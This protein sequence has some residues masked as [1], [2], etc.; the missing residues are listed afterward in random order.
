MAFTRFHDDECR[1]QKALDES[2]YTGNYFLNTP[3]NVGVSPYLFNDPHIRQQLWGGNL[4][5]NKTELESDLRGITRKLNRDIP[6]NNDYLEYSK[7]NLLYNKKF[8]P[9][10]HNEVTGQ[11][12]ATNPAWTYRE[13]DSFNS[14]VPNNFNYL[15]L[16]PQENICVPF[17]H[18][19]QS[20]IVEKD[21]YAEKYH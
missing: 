18:N 7:N 3:G 2:V 6:R 11:S 8:T 15:H 14:N 4:S 13:I 5:L 19:V 12:R 17:P 20:R 10:Y 1:V 9:V 16:D 21:M